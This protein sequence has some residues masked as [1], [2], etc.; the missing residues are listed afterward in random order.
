MVDQSKI[1]KKQLF[2][3][4]GID[5]LV[6]KGL[7]AKTQAVVPNNYLPLSTS[8]FNSQNFN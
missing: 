8:K 3:N 2:P 1:A 6:P 5:S 7:H 4:F